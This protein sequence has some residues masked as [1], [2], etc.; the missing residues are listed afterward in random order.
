MITCEDI[1]LLML[2]TDVIRSHEYISCYHN[3]K[4]NDGCY[5]MSA[6]YRPGALHICS[7]NSYSCVQATSQVK[8]RGHRGLV[9]YFYLAEVFL[10]TS[11]MWHTSDQLA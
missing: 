7:S 8:V 11:G 5:R 1:Y 3:I 10:A 4:N 6:D 2:D 9:H